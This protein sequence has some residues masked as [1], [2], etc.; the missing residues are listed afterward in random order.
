MRL[1][2]KMVLMALQRYWSPPCG[3]IELRQ[4]NHGKELYERFL[5]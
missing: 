2:G 5:V 1:L 3:I 4:L